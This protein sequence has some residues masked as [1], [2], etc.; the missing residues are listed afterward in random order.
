MGELAA[1]VFKEEL[2]ADGIE[3]GKKVDKENQRKHGDVFPVPGPKKLPVRDQEPALVHQ[4]KPQR[5]K[6]RGRHKKRISNHRRP[7][8]KPGLRGSR[9]E[10]HTSELQS[11]MY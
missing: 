8:E 11:P 10:E 5:H 7:T 2:P 1:G 4:E 9:S 3:S 6:D